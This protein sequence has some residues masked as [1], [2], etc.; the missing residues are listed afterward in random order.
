M[1]HRLCAGNVARLSFPLSLVNA[2]YSKYRSGHRVEARARGKSERYLPCK[3]SLAQRGNAGALLLFRFFTPDN[4]VIASSTRV[5][6]IDTV[7]KCSTET[8]LHPACVD[9]QQDQDRAT[10]Q[11]TAQHTP[12]PG[13]QMMHRTASIM[14][15]DHGDTLDTKS[16]LTLPRTRSSYASCGLFVESGR[17]PDNVNVLANTGRGSGC[18]G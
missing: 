2:E 17:R 9:T 1:G 5:I 8:A 12:L 18:I 13:T 4:I 6:V 10:G 15:E 14:D 11:A 3:Q 7:D 16:S